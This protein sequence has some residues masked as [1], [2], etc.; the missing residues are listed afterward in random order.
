MNRKICLASLK[1]LN[2]NCFVPFSLAVL[3]LLTCSDFVNAQ[4]S[5]Q[6]HKAGSSSTKR[7]TKKKTTKTIPKGSFVIGTK[8]VDTVKN[9][10]VERDTGSTNKTTDTSISGKIISG[11]VVNGK[12]TNLVRP[13]YPPQAKAVNAG[14]AVNVEVIIDEQGNVISATAVSG[15]P[16]LRAAA[17]DA[18]RQSKFNP[19]ILS[20]QPVKVSGVI[21][22]NFVP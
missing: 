3:L 15:H 13:V 7:T 22:Y 6:G 12:A 11:G 10:E 9:I 4:T 18:A 2:I 19:T 21:V 20:G 14:G 5:S 8:N 16:L 1:K 17:V